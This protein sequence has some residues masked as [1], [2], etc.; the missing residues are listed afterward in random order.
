[1]ERLIDSG[2]ESLT[3]IIMDMAEL[4]EKC[5]LNAIELYEKGFAK[6]TQIFEWSEKLRVSQSKVTDLA[7]ELIMRYQPVAKDLRYIRSCMEIAYGFSR[8]GR[9]AYDIVEVLETMGSFEK[10]DK[11]LVM[12][13][14]DIACEMIRLSI[15]A[16]KTKQ[17]DAVS[18]L[19]NM[20]NS[21][22][23]LYRN[24]LTNLIMLKRDS[25]NYLL[26]EDSSNYLLKDPHCAISALLILRYLERIADHA[27]YIG[28]SVCYIVTGQTSPRR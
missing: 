13:T 21:V 28:D 24:Y 12:K 26:K 2:L 5:V 11:S 9:Y 17:I 8:F 25:S 4:S 1:L 27:C 16:L 7:T 3:K 23:A 19:Y 10:C 15:N 14:S 18:K 20:D 6:R 22:D